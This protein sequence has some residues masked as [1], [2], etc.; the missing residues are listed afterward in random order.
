MELI[1]L[2]EGNTQTTKVASPAI[3]I[4]DVSLALPTSSTFHLPSSAHLR[5]YQAAVLLG[6]LRITIHMSSGKAR[7]I[8]VL[9]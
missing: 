3:S 9:K 7:Q 8:A 1:K 4:C 2:Q 6:M 5:P